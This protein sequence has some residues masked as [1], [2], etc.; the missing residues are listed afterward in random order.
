MDDN[1]NPIIPPI[2][3][4]YLITIGWINRKTNPFLQIHNIYEYTNLGELIH[5]NLGC[6]SAPT[7]VTC[8]S[9]ILASYFCMWPGLIASASTGTPKQLKWLS[10]F[11]STSPDKDYSKQKCWLLN[12]CQPKLPAMSTPW[13]VHCAS[14]P[15]RENLHQPNK[16]VSLQIKF[17][18]CKL[19]CPL[20]IWF[21]QNHCW[22]H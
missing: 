14:R 1:S 18:L 7:Q 3:H 16:E 6:L 15:T 5:F 19:H 10:K 17:A 8:I 13:H 2:P 12:L 22:S 21:K 9:V 20:N 11:I 4:T